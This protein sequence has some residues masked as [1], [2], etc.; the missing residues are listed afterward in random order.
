MTTPAPAA[1]EGPTTD[2]GTQPANPPAPPAAPTPPEPAAPTT[3]PE[4]VT[5]PK[6]AE[7]KAKAPKFEGDFDPERAMRAIESLREEVTE[8]KQKRAKDK[9][10]AADEQADFMKKLANLFGVQ[11]DEKKPPTP[12]ELAQQLDEARGETKESRAQARQTQ[13]ELAVYK[14]A[15]RYGGD[16]DALIDSR[17]FANAISKLDPSAAD[18]DEQV[19]KAVKTAVDANSKLAAK[20]PEPKEPEP[21]PAGGAPMDGA[22][23]GKRQLTGADIARMTPQQIKQATDEGRLNSYLSGKAG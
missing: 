7:P 2:T 4:P 1:P 14:T 23:G 5:E 19:G 6:S 9:Q 8:Q 18:F 15:G 11:T 12:E 10:Q 20:A 16:P 13:V 3:T 17:A 22:G 21:T